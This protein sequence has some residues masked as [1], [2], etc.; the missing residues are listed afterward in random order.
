MGGDGLDLRRCVGPQPQLTAGEP[1]ADVRRPLIVTTRRR[2]PSVRYLGALVVAAVAVAG[3]ACSLRG[4]DGVGSL[5]LFASVDRDAVSGAPTRAGEL[6]PEVGMSALG[7]D[8]PGAVSGNPELPDLEADVRRFALVLTGCQ[9]SSA[10]LTVVDGSARAAVDPPDEQV[11][12]GQAEYY[13]AVFDVPSED[14]P[15]DV[16]LP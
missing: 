4:D 5:V 1:R 15:A 10:T 14:V 7:L 3:S 8:R 13:L 12:C 6:T 2:P 9:N 11:D 16:R